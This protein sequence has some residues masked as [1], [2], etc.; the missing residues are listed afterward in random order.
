M[1]VKESKL[2]ELTREINFMWKVQTSNEHNALCVA[3]IDARDLFDLL[4]DVVGPANWSTEYIVVKDQMF[5][6][7]GINIEREDGKSEWVYKMDTGTEAQT[8][9]E[10]SL[11][12][13][14][15]KRVGIQ[16]GAG[17]FLYSKEIQKLKTKKHTNNKYYPVDDSGNILWDGVQI[18]KYI[19]DKLSNKAKNIDIKQEV[20][21]ESKSEISAAVKTRISG[22]KKEDIVGKDCLTKFLPDYN[23]AKKIEYKLAD[24]NT[25]M[26]LIS[27]MDFIDSIPPK[28]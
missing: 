20:K 11:V 4:D 6:R 12:S 19:N 21:Q 5:C 13:D 14:A 25:D 10:K 9:A 18:T 1:S 23:K 16:W 28:I 8:E 26:K 3:Y 17:R 2:K 15:S 7:M 24:L 22:M 27:L